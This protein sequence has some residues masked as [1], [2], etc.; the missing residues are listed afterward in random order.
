MADDETAPDLT[1]EKNR[2]MRVLWD[3]LSCHKAYE[4]KPSFLWNE[5]TGCVMVI[6]LDQFD[7]RLA[8]KRVLTLASRARN[9][10]RLARK[11]RRRR[12]SKGKKNQNQKRCVIRQ[13]PA[14]CRVPN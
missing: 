1:L 10:S 9:L 11:R 4:N 14:N 6:N 13:W 7:F 12:V 8:P 5:E 2:L 3:E